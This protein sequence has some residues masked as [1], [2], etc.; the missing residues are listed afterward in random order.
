MASNLRRAFSAIVSGNV[1]EAGMEEIKKHGPFVIEGD[2]DIMA[3][4]DKLLKEFIDQKRILL[5]QNE[6]VPCYTL[7][8]SQEKRPET[9]N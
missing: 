5:S 1:K 4:M 9:A 2:S 6:Y 7:R 3:A 8:N